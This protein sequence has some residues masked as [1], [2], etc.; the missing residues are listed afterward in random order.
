MKSPRSTD[1]PL[2]VRMDCRGPA[3]A[4]LVR[5][6]EA[7]AEFSRTA[8]VLAQGSLFDDDGT[9]CLGRFYR[10]VVRITVIEADRRAHPILIGFC[11]PTATWMTNMRPEKSSS[12]GIEAVRIDGAE[13]GIMP[14]NRAL[15]AGRSQGAKDCVT[16][17]H[18]H[19][20]PDPHRRR[21]HRANHPARRKDYLERAK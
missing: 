15:R 7:A 18:R 2:Y 14:G 5:Y 4:Y 21:L 1:R 10:R 8:R 12:L 20:H 13:I 11:A 3:H 19:G 16:H 17:R 6:A 9:S